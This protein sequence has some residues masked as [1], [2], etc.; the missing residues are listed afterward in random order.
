MKNYIVASLLIF[1]VL[2]TAPLTVLNLR[3]ASSVADSNS[4]QEES[5]VRV[6][7]ASSGNIITVDINEYL[8]GAVASEMPASFDE[9]ALKAQAVAC[10]TYLLWT[11]KNADNPEKAIS[12]IT[13]DSNIHQGFSDKSRLKEMW[14]KKYD[15]YYQKISDAVES[16]KDEYIQYNGEP[17]NAVFHGLSYGKTNSS[18]E[19]WSEALP[20]LISVEAPG[21]KLSSDL[22][23]EYK[24]TK[25]K[26]LQA[27]KASDTDEIIVEEKTKNGFIRS[28][29]IGSRIF[30]SAEIR[31]LLSLKSP[32]F[33][34]KING[35]NVIFTLHGKGHGL[36]MSQ[37][38]ADFMARQGSDYKDILLHFYPGTEIV[39]D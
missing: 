3:E 14:G 8:I 32:N 12:D 25:S 34:I 4:T 7:Q 37:Y 39:K 36:G 22:I 27:A 33:T 2:C 19:I 35:E 31:S 10:Y 11:R 13:D 21:D 18:E 1:F 29:R 20:Y 26:L 16:V 5:N 9:E 24:T 23:S 28:L 6:L 15:L 30:S 17:I 38:S